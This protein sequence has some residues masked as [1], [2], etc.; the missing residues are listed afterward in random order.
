MSAIWRALKLRGHLVFI[1]IAGIISAALL[2]YRRLRSPSLS[3]GP[4]VE[5]QRKIAA[6]ADRNQRA[7]A[8]ARITAAISA[9][10]AQGLR[11]QYQAALADDD[12]ERRGRRLVELANGLT[13]ES[14]K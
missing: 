2:A 6:L 11:D 9:T 12:E 14:E 7:V 1:G 13:T 3:L 10:K 4:T 8:E 5:H